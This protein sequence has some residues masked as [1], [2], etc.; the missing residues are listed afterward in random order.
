[1]ISWRSIAYAVVEIN[2][3]ADGGIGYGV[4]RRR[5]TVS[6]AGKPLINM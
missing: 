6:V 2:H 3:A 1:M 5:P 4:G